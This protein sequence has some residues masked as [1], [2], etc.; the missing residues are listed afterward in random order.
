MDGSI[1]P[2]AE[3]C[4]VAHAHGALTFVDEVHAV[5]LYGPRGGGIAERDGVT[6]KV[7]V[8][9]GTLG[10]AVG[11]VGGYIAGG[12]RSGGRRALLRP[13]LHLHHGAAAPRG[14]GGPGG[15]AGFG[16]PRGGSPAPNPP[17]PRQTPAG[18]AARQGR[19]RAARPQ[20][21]RPRARWGRPGR[22]PAEPGPARAGAVRPGHQ[23]PHRAQGGGTAAHRAHPPPQPCHDGA[24]GRP[25]VRVLGGA[26]A[27]PG[28]PPGPLLRLVPAAPALLPHERLGAAALPA[29]G[30]PCH[31]LT[32]P[33]PGGRPDSPRQLQS[34]PRGR[35]NPSQCSQFQAL[36]RYGSGGCSSLLGGALGVSPHCPFRSSPS[37]SPFSSH[38]SQSLPVLPVT[39]AI[40]QDGTD[41]ASVSLSWGWGAITGGVPQFPP[42]YLPPS[43]QIPG[44]SCPSQCSQFQAISRDGTDA[45]SVQL[46][47]GGE[48]PKFPS[49][50]LLPNFHPLPPKLLGFPPPS[51][52]SWVPPSAPSSR[53]STIMGWS[54]RPLPEGVPGGSPLPLPLPHLGPSGGG[55]RAPLGAF[56][57]LSRFW[58]MRKEF[59][60][61]PAPRGG[62]TPPAM[63]SVLGGPSP[64]QSAQSSRAFPSA[65]NTR[66]T[67]AK[68]TEVSG[69]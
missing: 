53:P 51:A 14:G 50:F 33:K 18:A 16:G 56:L 15:P 19:P 45:L 30:G 47:L 25:A 9:S 20:P 52:P 54:L 12:G 58:G 65:T 2:L 23:P 7:D 64:S 43:P 8:V 66:R 11:A 69:E 41:D 21:H 44:S 27:A 67:G 37:F 49:Q 38:P 3:L 22:H 29:G 40:N 36:T 39:M 42:Q 10:K 6:G 61:P 34:P 62:G 57:P 68:G 24:P 28:H 1:A 48:L 35:L 60:L 46:S 59:L 63:T 4:D 5:G 13:R 55:G 17:A 32:P 26:G 31:G